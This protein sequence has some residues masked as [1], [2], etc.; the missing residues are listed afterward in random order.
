MGSGKTTVSEKL[1]QKFKIP[2]FE[3]DQYFFLTEGK[4]NWTPEKSELAHKWCLESVSEAIKEGQNVIVANTFINEEYLIP[5]FK[6]GHPVKIVDM[7]GKYQNVHNVSKETVEAA[8]KK[9]KPLSQEF[10]DSC[11]KKYEIKIEVKSLN[12]IESFLVSRSK[13]DLSFVR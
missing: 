12:Q 13:E 4:Y 3:A 11:H 9:Y 10:L 2:Y 6:L 1:S 8:W 7:H 5:Y